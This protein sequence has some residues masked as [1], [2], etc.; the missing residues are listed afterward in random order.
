MAL[1]DITAGLDADIASVA[2]GLVGRTIPP[3]SCGTLTRDLCSKQRT[4]KEVV[5]EHS[6]QLKEMQ[7]EGTM[8]LNQM[9]AITTAAEQGTML[10]LAQKAHL[11]QFYKDQIEQTAQLANATRDAYN[12][13]VLGSFSSMNWFGLLTAIPSVYRHCEIY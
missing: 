13:I 7:S 11:E 12:N 5:H 8:A 6:I 1:H 9:S 3:L 2:T 10:V 4:A